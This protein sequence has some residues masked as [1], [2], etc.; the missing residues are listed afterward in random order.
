MLHWHTYKDVPKSQSNEW[1]FLYGNDLSLDGDLTEKQF[2]LRK[3]V[4]EVRN[5]KK[6]FLLQKTSFREENSITIDSDCIATAKSIVSEMDLVEEDK[7]RLQYHVTKFLSARIDE[8]SMKFLEELFKWSLEFNL[9]AESVTF[10]RYFVNNTTCPVYF[11]KSLLPM[12]SQKFSQHLFKECLLDLTVQSICNRLTDTLRL[13]LQFKLDPNSRTYNGSSLII[14]SYQYNFL[15]GV[16]LLKKY[17]ARN[18]SSDEIRMVT[19]QFNDDYS[20]AQLNKILYPKGTT[21]PISLQH[22]CIGSVRHLPNL[23][24]KI[25]ILPVPLQKDILTFYETLDE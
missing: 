10:L 25:K 16:K 23:E 9:I 2:E 15:P 24:D 13:L 5:T 8:N 1:T 6:R 22:L 7:S 11:L 17:G 3:L 20:L 14:L 12:V 19:T 4:I 18:P 21:A